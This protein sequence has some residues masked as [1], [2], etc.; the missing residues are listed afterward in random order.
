[1]NFWR[2]SSVLSV[3]RPATC[4]QE[5][6][7]AVS[8]GHSPL[9]GSSLVSHLSRWLGTLVPKVPGHLCPTRHYGM[10]DGGKSAPK[11]RMS[12]SPRGGRAVQPGSDYLFMIH[13]QGPGMAHPRSQ[14]SD[15][16]AREPPAQPQCCC[17]P[18][19]LARCSE[20]ICLSG[21]RFPHSPLYRPGLFQKSLTEGAEPRDNHS[22]DGGKVRNLDI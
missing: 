16:V 11:L 21:E 20:L 6:C 5:R 2:S 18:N 4:T 14:L 10:R 22:L 13:A 8:A 9:A 7:V 19:A 15:R 17:L 3:G 12:T 1:M